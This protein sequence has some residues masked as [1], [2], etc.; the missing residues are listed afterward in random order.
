[1]RA[2]F[3]LETPFDILVVDDNSPDGTAQKV[4]TLQEEFSALHLTV[5]Q[6]KLGLGLAYIH[7]FKWALECDYTV[8]IEMDAISHTIQQIY[9]DL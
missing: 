4:K 6:E 9:H 1:M 8:I 5:R 7:G 2:V 3:S